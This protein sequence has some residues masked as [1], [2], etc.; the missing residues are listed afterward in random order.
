MTSE[1]KQ[2]KLSIVMKTVILHAIIGHETAMYS[3]CNAVAC[4]FLK[5]LTNQWAFG[6][7]LS[8]LSVEFFN[9]V[10]KEI[11]LGE[12]KLGVFTQLFDKMHAES[13]HSYNCLLHFAFHSCFNIHGN[14]DREKFDISSAKNYEQS[15]VAQ[16]EPV[17]DIFD[18]AKHFSHVC[19]G[20]DIKTCDPNKPLFTM[21]EPK[22]VYAER[23]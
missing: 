3:H 23:K 18:A 12:G 19:T 14:L 22:I 5:G 13:G 15:I 10:G 2:Q 17:L 7:M 4:H 9:T 11:I 21:D 8:K 6:L 20:I 1:E 16:L